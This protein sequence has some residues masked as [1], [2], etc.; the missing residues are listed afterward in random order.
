M[1]YSQFFF[2]PLLQRHIVYYYCFIL[3]DF[4][5]VPQPLSSHLL[6]ISVVC[7]IIMFIFCDQFPCFSHF[8]CSSVTQHTWSSP[9]KKVYSCILI[10]FHL[11]FLFWK[12]QACLSHAITIPWYSDIVVY[13]SYY[14]NWVLNYCCWHFTLV[15][16]IQCYIKQCYGNRLSF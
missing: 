4:R 9:H 5:S 11:L 10:S 2:S 16:Y 1:R 13:R 6:A 14:L 8:Y 12:F 15:H 3:F 7:T